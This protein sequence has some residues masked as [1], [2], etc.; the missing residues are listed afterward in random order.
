[1]CKSF[2]EPDLGDQLTAV[3]F[4]V[5]E[6]VWNRELYPNFVPETLPWSRNKPSDRQLIA[7]E[8]RNATNYDN[9]VDKVGGLHNVFLRDFLLPLRL[10]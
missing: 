7:L 3:C 4:L 6:R 8:D 2:H 10:A 9:W 1:M 5:D